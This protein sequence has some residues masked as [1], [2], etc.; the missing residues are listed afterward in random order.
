LFEVFIA[1]GRAMVRV[2][3]LLLY[4]RIL[5]E[6]LIL[7]AK[8]SIAIF[9]VDLRVRKINYLTAFIFWAKSEFTF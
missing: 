7:R 5:L 3:I 4:I 1:R 6:L 9:A 2:N 8:F